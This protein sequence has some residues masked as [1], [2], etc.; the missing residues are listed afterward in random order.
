M[1]E[2]WPMLKAETLTDRV[3]DVVR[4]KILSGQM[5]P[6]EFVREQDISERL[7]VSRTPVRE[8]LARL[9]S[10]SFLERMPHKG[11][12]LPEETVSELIELYPIITALE[13]LGT[14]E[15]LVRL[16]AEVIAELKL[17]N[18]RYEAAYQRRDIYAGI[19]LNHQFH[20]LL[21]ERSGNQRLS[22]MLDELR[23]K[24]RS[25]EIWA[26]SDTR[27]WPKSIKQHE[28]ILEALTAGDTE[29]ALQILEQNRLS[30]FR[31]FTK[32]KMATPPTE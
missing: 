9:A 13:V 6:G 16:D 24:V 21:S 3:Y 2:Q 29:R 10:E 14:R 12:R 15:A 28:S 17:I 1:S 23:A 25:L 31:E 19:D 11:F 22:Q 30:T 7:G 26:F 32:Q 8:A 18:A 5:A 20:H 27:N 4:N